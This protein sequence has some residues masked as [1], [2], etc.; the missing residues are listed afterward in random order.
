[1]KDYLYELRRNIYE[2]FG[3]SK[4]SKPGLNN[5]DKKLENYLNFRN[6]FFIEVG[7][8]DGYRQ[9]N[10]YYL[11]KFL[12]WHGILVEGIPSLYKECKRIRNNSSVYNCALVAPDFP[13]SFVQMHYANLMSV[14]ENSLKNKESQYE[15]IQR[16]LELQKIQQSYGIQVPAK[17]LESI[18]DKFAEL[19]QIDF[20]SLDVE[21]YELD[22]LKGINLVK[23]Q[24]KYILVEAR[25]FEEI[26]LYLSFNY[27]LIDQLSHHDY[28]YRLKSANKIQ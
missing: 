11:E 19:P 10:T 28:L 25:F 14:V 26:N 18:L 13:D 12:G 1:M 21:G 15:H 7:A 3:N 5:L 8:N 4:Y 17:T 27:D 20:L 23:Y 2:S 9:S 22:V 6:G 24:P 16:G